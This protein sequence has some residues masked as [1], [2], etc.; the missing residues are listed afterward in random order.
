MKFKNWEEMYNYII[1]QGDLYNPVLEEY[2]FHYNTDGAICS[3]NVSTDEATALA[4]I[5]NKYN[6]YWGAMLGVGGKIYDNDSYDR[7]KETDLYLKPS[8]DYCKEHYKEDSWVSTVEYGR[9]II[10]KKEIFSM[11]TLKS[12]LELY[13]DWD[14]MI[15]INDYN[16]NTIIESTGADIYEN[17]KDLLYKTVVAFG[18]YNDA[19]TVRL[20]HKE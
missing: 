3:Y 20:N 14:G 1:K 2:V 10:R 13:D 11:T 19:L 9:N 6:E 4:K 16:T 17:K 15:K 5:A 12:F 18:F 8:Y 7:E